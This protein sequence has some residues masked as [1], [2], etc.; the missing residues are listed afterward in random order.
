MIVT[1]CPEVTTS[2]LSWNLEEAASGDR[3][4]LP[5]S[6]MSKLDQ[7]FTACYSEVTQSLV[8]LSIITQERLGRTVQIVTMP[9]YFP[10][11]LPLMS[12]LN[13]TCGHAE[14][15]HPGVVTG[16]CRH[17][18]RVNHQIINATFP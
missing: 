5:Q 15:A 10:P 9:G 1:V 13:I 4:I 11:D 18:R 12:S 17:F 8:S 3:M 16:E 6:P 2:T 14:L 7:A